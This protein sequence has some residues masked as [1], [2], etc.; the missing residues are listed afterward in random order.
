M[1]PEVKR[2]LEEGQ[3]LSL[4]DTDTVTAVTLLILYL[5]SLLS[6]ILLRLLYPITHSF[7]TSPSFSYSPPAHLSPISLCIATSYLS[8]LPSP[9]YP[10]LPPPISLPFSLLFSSH[11]FSSCQLMSCHIAWSPVM[12]VQVMNLKL[13]EEVEK[14]ENM[15]KLQSAINKDLHKVIH[16]Y[17]FLPRPPSHSRPP[18]LPISFHF[19]FSPPTSI[20]NSDFVIALVS[21]LF[22]NAYIM[23]YYAILYLSHT[24]FILYYFRSW[25]HQCTRETK[26]KKN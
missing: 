12:S 13:T 18:S 24:I 20:C 14:L 5:F 3:S 16:S 23:L 22:Y 8:S 6:W 25:K 2:K 11:L 19:S 10:S 26:T 9:L 4:I 21:I 1:L 7:I 15:L 17:T